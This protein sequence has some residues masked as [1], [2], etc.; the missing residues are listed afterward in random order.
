MFLEEMKQERRVVG[1]SPACTQCPFQWPLSC[2]CFTCKLWGLDSASVS[3]SCTL[4]MATYNRNVAAR[5]QAERVHS[6]PKILTHHILAPSVKSWAC[7]KSQ[8]CCAGRLSQGYQTSA[9]EILRITR[10]LHHEPAE[11][12]LWADLGVALVKPG[13]AGLVKGQ[14]ASAGK[15]KAS[16]TRAL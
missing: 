14:A 3:K 11:S 13:T 5:G 1:S 7:I 4:C 9:H 6:T 8:K 15:Y 16:Q 12:V 10:D 2:L